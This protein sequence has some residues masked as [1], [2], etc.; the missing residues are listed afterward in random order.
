MGSDKDSKD[1]I[2]VSTSLRRL[3]ED[4]LLK[5]ERAQVVDA[6]QLTT[7][8]EN[9]LAVLAKPESPDTWEQHDVALLRLAAI[10][11]GGACKPPLA[12]TFVTLFREPTL[13]SKV[14]IALESERTHLACTAMD[15][16]SATARLGSLWEPLVPAYLPSL[17]SLLARANK[18]YVSRASATLRSLIRNT[19]CSNI[20]PAIAVAFDSPSAT[21]RLGCAEALLCCLGG[22]PER[23]VGAVEEAE[24]VEKEGMSV[25][26][27][28]L[29]KKNG[30]ALGDAG[31]EGVMRKAGRDRDPKI[32]SICRRIWE[33]Y[34]RQWPDRAA[35]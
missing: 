12:S 17:L 3:P 14:R 20:V 22:S 10:A 16:L 31:I 4:V 29:E 21:N 2:L 24:K 13:V 15:A 8:F 1:K 30:Q 34:R 6:K 23:D 26:K 18:V 9:L 28:G 11:R 5:S 19:G 27:A 7:E 33:I 35:V 32:R 25:S